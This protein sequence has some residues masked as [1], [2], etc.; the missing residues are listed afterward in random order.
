MNDIGTPQT[1]ATPATDTEDLITQTTTYY[2][3]LMS[4]KP[5]QPDAADIFHAKL[6]EKKLTPKEAKK[7]EG[8]ITEEEV[9][10]AISKMARGKASGPDGVPSEF[11]IAMCNT[12]A[13]NITNVLN[14]AFDSRSLPPSMLLGQI[15]LLYKKKTR[16]T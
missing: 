13:L 3:C 14:S 7:L 6:A 2:K 5:S 10:K 9:R 15:T 4:E 8:A 11:Y 1:Q 12:I 16:E